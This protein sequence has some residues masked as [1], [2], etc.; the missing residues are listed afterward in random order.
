[1]PLVRID[2]PAATPQPEVAA[3]SDAVHQALVQLFRVPEDDRFQVIGRRAPDELVCAP[4]YLG[5]RHS[6]QVVVVQI[7]CAPGRPVAMKEQLYAR[8]ASGIAAGTRFAA[9]D[10]IINLVETLRENWSFGGGIAQYAVQDR[11]RAA[12]GAS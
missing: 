4:S 5:I 12:A 10:V 9:D 2:L 11:E 8:I 7:A 3:V 1:M 6:D